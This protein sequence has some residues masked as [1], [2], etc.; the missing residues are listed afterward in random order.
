MSL[1][2]MHWRC[3]I[4][5]HGHPIRNHQSS[6]SYEES[7]VKWGDVAEYMVVI[8]WQCKIILHCQCIQIKSLVERYVQFVLHKYFPHLALCVGFP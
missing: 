1:I 7:G 4:I 8:G 2:D 6:I 3:K 5:L